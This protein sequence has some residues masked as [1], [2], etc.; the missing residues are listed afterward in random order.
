MKTK[1]FI[2]IYLAMALCAKISSAQPNGPQEQPGDGLEWGSAVKGVELSAKMTND[3][4][5]VGSTTILSLQIRNLSTNVIAV[6]VRYPR[7][8]FDIY[9]T[10]VKS[11][12][13]FKMSPNPDNSFSYAT[14]LPISIGAGKRHAWEVPLYVGMDIK[15]SNYTVE[16]RK[17]LDMNGNNFELVSN[18][19]I[20]QVR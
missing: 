11:L 16:V 8:D 3:A 4:I 9:F 15:P 17:H 2:P 7:S 12:K 14:V 6:Y 19:L 5:T 1:L 20:L 13:R 10:N 18:P